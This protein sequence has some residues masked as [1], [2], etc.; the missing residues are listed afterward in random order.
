VS[1]RLRLFLALI[2]TVLA[3]FV[4]RLMYLQF[5]LAEEFRALSAENFLRQERIMPLRGR[6]LA[7]DGTVLADNRIA[8]DLMYRGGEILNWE[9]IRFLLGLPGDPR[10]PDPNNARERLEG[11]A[12]VAWNI[13]E[14]LIP[15]LQELTAGQPNL[16]LRQRIERTYPTNLA[17]HVV[18][19]TTEADPQRFPGHAL[20]DLVGQ[21]GLEAGLQRVLFGVPGAALVEVDNRG[22]V[23]NR[24][25][26]LPARPGQ[27]VTLTID[28]TVQ[29]LAEEALKNALPYVNADRR[30]RGLPPESVVRGAIIALNPQ[31]GDILAMASHP[32]F[33]Q[34]LFTRRPSPAEQITALLNDSVNFTLLNRA[35]EAYEPAST[36]KLVTSSALLEGGFIAPGS[37]FSCSGAFTFGG[38]TWR[39]WA[40]GFRGNQDTRQAIADSC[41]TFF[42]NAIAGTPNWT[43]GWAPFVRSLTERAREFGFGQPVGV[44]LPEEKAGR[45]PTDASSRAVRGHPWRPG[46]TLNIAIGQGDMLATPLQV[47]QLISTLALGGTKVQPR[48]IKAIGDE[49]VASEV[50]TVPGRHWRTLQEG[51]RML[52]THFPAQRVMGPRV[53][54][55]NVAGKTGTA[56]NP[57]GDGYF[58][59]WFMGYGPIENPELAVVVFIEHGGSSATVAVPT[60]RDF[61]AAFWGVSP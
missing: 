22:T 9:R 61:M 20:G 40:P 49:P 57:R 7:S 46:D 5:A 4:V 35:V 39:N 14:E 53:F 55:V 31:T 54:P 58:H 47:A 10:P 18:G 8:V 3:I 13:R 21:M 29:H 34:N 30:S 52:F 51:L 41:N 25:T 28:P 15:A 50:T 24:R 26:I 17:A 42:W 56:Q 45:V 16:Y 38:I 19:Y 32:T 23:L 11:A 37:R 43:V 12:V 48:L 59:A 36:F 1:Y 27:D 6:I 60:A 44:G 2:L 33:D